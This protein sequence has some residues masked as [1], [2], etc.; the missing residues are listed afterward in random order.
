MTFRK[1]RS[2]SIKY[3][4]TK[5]K[6]ARSS[7]PD[8]RESRSH[9]K[10]SMNEPEVSPIAFTAVPD[11]SQLE[12][13][14]G[15][16][17]KRRFRSSWS[18]SKFVERFRIK[19]QTKS[20][21]SLILPEEKPTSTCK[22]QS[23]EE[24]SQTSL[25]PALDV[26]I[27]CKNSSTQ[28][29]GSHKKLVTF[30]NRSGASDNINQQNDVPEIGD[31]FDDLDFVKAP[32]RKTRLRPFR[33]S[34][35]LHPQELTDS[36]LL[37]KKRLSQSPIRPDHSIEAT[38]G[39]TVEYI[40]NIE[41]EQPKEDEN[42]DMTVVEGNV[43][44]DDKEQNEPIEQLLRPESS[45][46]ISSRIISFLSHPLGR[47]LRVGAGERPVTRKRSFLER[48]FRRP[49][50]KTQDDTP[51]VKEE[52]KNGIQGFTINMDL[53][54]KHTPSAA[55]F[56][57]TTEDLTQPESTIDEQEDTI[58]N[59]PVA[60][61]ETKVD[62][63]DQSTMLHSYVSDNT[64][65]GTNNN[66]PAS[67]IYPRPTDFKEGLERETRFTN[68]M[69]AKSADDPIPT[70][71][72]A[73]TISKLYRDKPSYESRRRL[74]EARKEFFSPMITPV[75][76]PVKEEFQRETVSLDRTSASFKKV[77]D[78]INTQKPTCEDEKDLTPVNKALKHTDPLQIPLNA[79]ARPI[80]SDDDFKKYERAF[81]NDDTML[82]DRSN[83]SNASKKRYSGVDM[84]IPSDEEDGFLSA[85]QPTAEAESLPPQVESAMQVNLRK[86][87]SLRDVLKKWTPRKLRKRLHRNKKQPAALMEVQNI[88]SSPAVAPQGFVSP[89]ESKSPLKEI[90]VMSVQV[91]S[92][93]Q[94]SS[95]H[96]SANSFRDTR[97]RCRNPSGKESI[98]GYDYVDSAQKQESESLTNYLSYDEHS[99][100]GGS[101]VGGTI[102]GKFRHKSG[103]SD[104]YTPNA[105]T[106][107][108]YT[109]TFK[110]NKEQTK[111]TQKPQRIPSYIYKSLG[112]KGKV[113][114]VESK[115][116]M[117][118]QRI[119]SYIYRSPGYV[120]KEF[121]LKAMGGSGTLLP[122]LHTPKV[123]KHE[124]NDNVPE[125]I[126]S[127]ET[128]HTPK[129]EAKELMEDIWAKVG[130]EIRSFSFSKDDSASD[131]I[132]KSMEDENVQDEIIA[133]EEIKVKSPD[134]LFNKCT[135]LISKDILDQHTPIRR[136]PD[137]VLSNTS[138]GTLSNEGLVLDAPL[139]SNYNTPVDSATPLK[140]DDSVFTTKTTELLKNIT[141]PNVDFYN[142]AN[143]EVSSSDGS[144]LTTPHTTPRSPTRL[145]PH[146]TEAILADHNDL[147]YATPTKYTLKDNDIKLRSVPKEEEGAVKRTPL[148]TQ[149][150]IDDAIDGSLDTSELIDQFVCETLTKTSGELI[151]EPENTV[152]PL[153]REQ[154]L[155]CEER[156]NATNDDAIDTRL[157]T[158]ELIDQFVCETLSKVSGELI[159]EPENTVRPLN[160]EQTLVYEERINATN[161]DA[162]DTS[163]NTSELTDQ[164][165]C[166]TL[167]KVSGDLI[168]EPENTVSPLSSEQALLNQ[169]R[170][171]ATSN[172]AIDTSLN[173]SE[174]TDQL[175]CETLSKATD[176]LI[177]ELE[178]TIR[179]LSREQACVYK[180][181]IN[182]FFT[183]L[184]YKV[185]K[186]N[187]E[188]ETHHAKIS[189]LEFQKRAQYLHNLLIKQEEEDAKGNEDKKD[190]L[191]ESFKDELE[192]S[193]SDLNATGETIAT[194]SKETGIWLKHSLD[195]TPSYLHNSTMEETEDIS[196]VAVQG[197]F[198]ANDSRLFDDANCTIPDNS[199]PAVSAS[200][201]GSSVNCRQISSLSVSEGTYYT[202]SEAYVTYSEC[203]LT[204][205]SE[206]WSSATLCTDTDS[207]TSSHSIVTNLTNIPG[208]GIKDELLTKDSDPPR[209]ESEL[210][211]VSRGV[212]IAYDTDDAYGDVDTAVSNTSSE[213]PDDLSTASRFSEQLEEFVQDIIHKCYIR[214]KEEE[215][216]NMADVSKEDD[217][218]YV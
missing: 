13:K 45:M 54:K 218:V 55:S 1:K 173:T 143:W 74:L 112:D 113:E 111:S 139:F 104:K 152:S 14:Y 39:L 3:V 137:Q 56:H 171:N 35:L 20:A 15:R 117:T 121:K 120:M 129:G 32:S 118:P 42:E 80:M 43:D 215:S 142:I 161:D 19:T 34:K 209:S 67:V 2:T 107:F 51:W 36:V 186:T 72:K 86:R 135:H 76:T 68:A 97:F 199:E 10:S 91:E 26:P 164:F 162:I 193:T 4:G 163:L 146:M 41:E 175:V 48:A 138:I 167:S 73:D 61:S 8:K 66:T 95:A 50:A 75:P 82:S 18:A 174:L 110:T 88:K 208:V 70:S 99:T 89:D 157:N 200:N 94:G 17:K 30:N 214:V 180:E 7:T 212:D 102:Q 127:T 22:Y 84:L 116:E 29:T 71:Q 114:H 134:S 78:Y 182:A 190:E 64:P 169:E 87:K 170:I 205:A 185:D 159:R 69:R 125:P 115:T 203:E 46:S 179:P 31:E 119:P 149:P 59:T 65:H 11:G 217:V 27:A 58:A 131:S 150:T 145:M 124:S 25:Q 108:I 37:A 210:S 191:Q 147:V 40:N 128:K 141:T 197:S 144:Q 81:K 21:P 196:N 153:S 156:I 62:Y 38:E 181:R 201:S 130:E 136:D 44:V 122:Q 172:D 168:Q 192:S 103:G 133:R 151:Q 213:C 53:V 83:K 123:H 90:Q 189:A 188:K 195:R 63:A 96:S 105:A 6:D 211:E 216:E 184:D 194:P 49:T 177:E 100:G 140:Q 206:G 160:R 12:Q 60:P 92:L 57:S 183:G 16:K 148:K 52:W 28:S 155:V 9:D 165:V 5:A 24:N 176:E 126:K 98:D 207:K 202:A 166:E 204:T 93:P 106:K 198:L 158:S 109:P 85:R 178:N 132:R 154:T 23:P 77:L 187:L 79:P 33:R 101:G 47:S